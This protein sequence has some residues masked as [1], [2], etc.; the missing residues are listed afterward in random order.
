MNAMEVIYVRPRTTPQDQAREVQLVDGR[1]LIVDGRMGALRGRAAV[2]GGDEVAGGKGEEIAGCVSGAVSAV[3]FEAGKRNSDLPPKV[4]GVAWGHELPF[5][6]IFHRC[7][8]ARR[9]WS[10]RCGR[11]APLPREADASRATV[12]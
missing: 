12:P 6:Q 4:S 9:H 3:L 5:H 7:A 11:L 10:A 8:G 2:S 1:W